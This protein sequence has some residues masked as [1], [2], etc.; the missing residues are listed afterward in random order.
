MPIMSIKIYIFGEGSMWYSHILGK[1]DLENCLDAFL[2]DR[3]Q[4]IYESDGHSGPQWNIDLQ[5]YADNEDIDSLIQRLT[6]FMRQWGVLDR[7]L[8]FTIVRESD[9]STWEHRRVDG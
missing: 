5:L 4:V 8:N 6:T 3:G 7:S 1:R 2:K 9:A